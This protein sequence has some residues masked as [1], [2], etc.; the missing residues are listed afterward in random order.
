MIDSTLALNPKVLTVLKKGPL[1]SKKEEE[2]GKSLLTIDE[3]SARTRV[4]SRTIRFYQSKCVLPRP[5]IQGRVA[6]YS[7]EHLER[8]ELIAQLQD[9]GLNMRAIKDLTEKITKGLVSLNEWL[10]LEDKLHAPW[11]DDA[12]VLYTEKE[13][14]K[15][16]G[17]KRPGLLADL[18]QNNLVD[19]QSDRYLVNS[20]ALLT[21]ATSLEK[22]GVA[23]DVS[24]EAANIIRKHMQ[25]MSNELSDLFVKRAGDG[26]GDE[27]NGGSVG[28]VLDAVRK[29]ALHAVTTIFSHAMESALHKLVESG[30]LS[31]KVSKS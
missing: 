29:H 21:I 19:R 14:F 5:K 10:G 1:A 28:K 7:Q 27:I 4:P 23:L 20:P 12:P 16:I 2:A 30:K 18:L 11:S 3:L 24:H 26:F 17:D 8:L 22:S 31:D 9:R 25:K 15:A 6:Y 13:L